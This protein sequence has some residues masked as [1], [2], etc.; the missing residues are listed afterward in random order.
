MVARLGLMHDSCSA[1]SKFQDKFISLHLGKTKCF[2]YG[3]HKLTPGAI[4]KNKHTKKCTG[5]THDPPPKR[6][7]PGPRAQDF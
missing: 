6:K 1:Y 7:D 4:K 3:A 2:E 5:C